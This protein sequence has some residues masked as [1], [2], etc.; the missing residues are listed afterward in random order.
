[1]TET[2]LAPLIQQPLLALFAIVGLGLLVGSIEIAGI[3]LGSSGVI[4]VA[5]A[6]GHFGLTVP[7]QAGQIGL[8]LFVY[9][10]GIGAG[11]RF[12]GALKRE[13]SQLARL[14]VV[15]VG[16][17]ALLTWALAESFDLSP[18]LATGIFAGAMTSTPALASAIEGGGEEARAAV[19]GYGVAYPLGVIG[20]VLFV[21]LLPRLLKLPLDAGS[22]DEAA[23]ASVER[24]LVEV[25]NPN[26]F[27]RRFSDSSLAEIGACQVARIWRNERMEPVRYEDEFA[28]GQV[29]LLVGDPKAVR[30]ATTL[31]GK[32]STKEVLLDADNERDRLVVTRPEIVGKTIGEIAPLK[33]HG[34]VITRVDRMEFT[35]SPDYATR[36]EK[37]DIL[38]VV[39]PKTQLKRFEA[40]LGHKAQAFSETSLVS[41]TIGVALGIGVGLWSIP[42]P[43]GSGFA[44]GL[45]GGPLLVALLLGHFGRVGGIIGHI[46]RPTRILLQEMGLVFFLADAG[47]KGGATI[48]EAVETQGVR[49]FLV[50]ALITLVP[51]VVGYLTARRIFGMPIGQ[52][53]GGICG[54]MTS[55]PA[56]GAIVAKTSR[57]APIVSYATVYPVAVILMAL[58]AKMLVAIVS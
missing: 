33:D 7:N 17:G 4:F 15:V 28:A 52:T 19:V 1:M 10:V 45:A 16:S 35:F 24:Q 14:A 51:M 20:V 31:V 55:T 12:F 18:G 39:G 22:D 5:L 44:L 47:V 32:P 21:Q 43:G 49:I 58:L 38:T 29:V 50:G 11:G 46:P 9:C 23:G 30:I 34:V 53:L 56:L 27:G 36:L 26:M 6:A 57:Q 54:G 8:A 41:L 40:H 25:T 2:I 3:S 37:N 42:L 48:V 13:G